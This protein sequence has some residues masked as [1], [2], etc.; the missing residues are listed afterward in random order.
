MRKGILRGKV[1]IKAKMETPIFRKMAI[2]IEAFH[3]LDILKILMK[4]VNTCS[5]GGDI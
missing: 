3:I 5:T 1:K 4:E 2:F